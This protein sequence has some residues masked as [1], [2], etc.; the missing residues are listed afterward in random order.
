MLIYLYAS[1]QSLQ[2]NT[3]W[4]IC[5][6]TLADSD[7]FQLIVIDEACGVA[8]DGH[9]FRPK[10][11]SAVRTLKL[12]YDNQHSKCNQIAMSTIFRKCDQ[13]MVNEL[14]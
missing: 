5:L 11:L 9:D 6:S 7:I 1:S 8:Q 3:F 4:Y 10:F 14:Y 13:D 2:V 12:L